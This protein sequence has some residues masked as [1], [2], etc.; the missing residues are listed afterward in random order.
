M[1]GLHLGVDFADLLHLVGVDFFV[2]GKDVIFQGR[3]PAEQPGL[4]SV[5]VDRGFVEGEDSTCG[6]ISAGAEPPVAA[7]G[8][9]VTE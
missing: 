6:Y 5:A 3:G 9:V 1:L 4:A 2:G 8:E 7:G